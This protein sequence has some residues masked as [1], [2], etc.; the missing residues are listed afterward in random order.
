MLVD[1]LLRYTAAMPE[2][3]KR[4]A[5]ER[6]RH[7]LSLPVQEP[8]LNRVVVAHGPNLAELMNYLPPEG[9]LLIFRPLG[10]DTRPSFEYLASVAPTQWDATLKALG[11]R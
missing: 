1:V 2:A 8:G 11:L 10:L 7:W 3:E 4:P 9:T 5:I 6:T